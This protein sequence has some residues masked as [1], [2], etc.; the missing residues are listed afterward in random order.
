MQ[1]ICPSK[2]ELMNANKFKPVAWVNHLPKTSRQSDESFSEQM[3]IQQ[4]A[5]ECIN[6]YVRSTTSAARNYLITGPPGAGK[7]HCMSHSIIYALAQG[8]VATTT[9]VLAD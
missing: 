3:E 1:D 5:S 9:A 2:D 7:T 8:L 4:Q 6:T